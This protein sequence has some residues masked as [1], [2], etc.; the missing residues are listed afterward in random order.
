MLLISLTFFLIELTKTTTTKKKLCYSIPMDQM[1]IKL[2]GLKLK[3]GKFIFSQESFISFYFL[4]LMY[5]FFIYNHHP[6][7]ESTK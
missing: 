2:W 3:T 7:T 6:H 4:R 1:K 5:I